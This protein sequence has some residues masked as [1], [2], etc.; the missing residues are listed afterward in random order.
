MSLPLLKKKKPEEN[1]CKMVELR[2]YP[3]NMGGWQREMMDKMLGM[4]KLLKEKQ[5]KIDPANADTYNKQL[6]EYY[7]K[8]PSKPDK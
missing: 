1:P 8:N 7:E 6:L 4:V 5:T 2:V 3:D